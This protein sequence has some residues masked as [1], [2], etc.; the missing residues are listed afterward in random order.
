M[1]ELGIEVGERGLE[2][3]AVTRMVSGIQL[4]E[5]ALAREQEGLALVEQ[6]GFLRRRR[7]SAGL[8]VR[9]RFGLLLFDGFAFPSPG[10]KTIIRG[11]SRM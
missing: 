3:C 7:L 8:N 9:L 11:K 5:S 2:H 4:L 1:F 6:T 10:H